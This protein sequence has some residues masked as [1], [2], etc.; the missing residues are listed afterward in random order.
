MF[1]KIDPSIHKALIIFILLSIG[2]LVSVG[3]SQAYL[4]N[5]SD[6][7]RNARQK[8]RVWKNKIVEAKENNSI[9]IEYE[10]PYL[11]LIE[12]N[13][14]GDENRLSWFEVLQAQATARGMDAFKFSTASQVKIVS[15][16]ISPLFRSLGIYK[17]IMTINMQMAHEGDMFALFNDLEANAKGLFSVDKCV[18]EY[19]GRAVKKGAANANVEAKCELSWYSIRPAQS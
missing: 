12:N 8:M 15:K 13:I 7:E 2:S 3:V 17:S 6:N 10:K 4:G 18:V 1:S 9:I 16:E 5:V 14:V 11:S 19:K